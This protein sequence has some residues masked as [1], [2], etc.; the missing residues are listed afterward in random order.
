MADPFPGSED[1]LARAAGPADP[2]ASDVPS[3]N[4]QTPLNAYGLAG[5][6]RCWMPEHGMWSHKYHLDGRHPENESVPHS[7]VYYSLNVLLGLSTVRAAWGGEP[8][9]VPALFQSLCNILPTR[10]VRNGAW[11]MALWAGAELDMAAPGLVAD[12][13][14]PLAADAEP[15]AGWTAQDLGLSVS[16]V[17]AQAQRDPSWRP[18]ADALFRLLYERFRGPGALVRDSSRGGRRHFATFASQVYAAL[19]FYH[20][21]ELT[22]DDRALAAANAISA[23]LIA[24]QGPLGE[25][26]WF[27]MPG[28]DRVLDAYEVYSVH[29]H[30]MAPAFLHHSVKHGVP[31]ARE[32]IVRGYEWIFGTNQMR[33]S[34]LLPALSLIY[35]S[36]ARRGFQGRRIGRVLRSAL[37][38][39]TGLSP[40]TS[41]PAS[42]RLTQ[43]MRSYEFGWLLWSFGNRTD[44]PAFTQHRAFLPPA[45]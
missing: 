13:L 27:Y 20:Y 38:A 6:R 5:L 17:A 15:A 25:W 37:V 7:D 36:Q 40:W 34:M 45:P 24:L 29:Q 43:E 4:D 12:R 11:G 18:L 1:T 3:V 26:P 2:T 23:K 9:D 16:G 10:P 8:Y 30:G 42:L 33:Q 22:G 21:G 14:R 35:R 41:D 28:G 44:Y 32:A 39:A 19:A 31:G